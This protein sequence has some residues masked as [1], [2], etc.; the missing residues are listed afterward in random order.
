MQLRIVENM[1]GNR[2]FVYDD[3]IY[4]Y[5]DLR[6]S[7]SKLMNLF[8]RLQVER[9]LIC[10][11]QGFY[12]YATLAAAYI[13]RV[14]FCCINH[15]DP[16]ERKKTISSEFMPQL[17]I[18]DRKLESF[19]NTK[20]VFDDEIDELE[21]ENAKQYY[22]KE[23]NIAYVVY[24]SGT[25]GFPKGVKIAREPF[26]S[27]IIWIVAHF[28]IEC[29]DIGSQF[30]NLNFDMSLVDIFV[31]LYA[32]SSLV[33]F[34]SFKDKLFPAK[35]IEKYQISFWNSVPGVIDQLCVQGKWNK[36][37]MHSIKKFKF[38]GDEI[39]K[40]HMDKVFD[41]NANAE[42]FLSYGPTEVTLFCCCLTLNKNNYLQ[43]AKHNMSLGT[44]LPGWN[45]MLV[46]IEEGLGEIVVYGDNIGIGYINE[47]YQS[48]FRT[49]EIDGI[50]H[51]AYYT[52][53]YGR[54][55]DQNLYFVS[56]MDLQVKIN[57][58]RCDLSEINRIVRS[59]VGADAVTIMHEKRIYV[60]YT[61]DVE[62]GTIYSILKSKI[63]TYMMP[64]YIKHVNTLPRNQNGKVD[65]ICLVNGI[66]S[67]RQ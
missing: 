61:A 11:P 64:H 8:K 13:C 43:Y 34:P 67:C 49:I 2:I 44:P 37:V 14:T 12:A 57:G 22:N 47:S 59:E 15:E 48:G 36:A 26:A 24:T 29:Y 66:N 46:D 16:I 41:L 1:K 40:R 21:S 6:R 7:V 50:K 53:D 65:R 25:T 5:T 45:I 17:I 51:R 19:Y 55:I 30:P 63:P 33:P 58:N 56:R 42:V 38:G 4:T 28:G 27:A 52:G 9:V 3:K 18:Q 10:L 20:I 35:R 31:A 39:L 23:N 54:Y 32:G 62:S 60:F